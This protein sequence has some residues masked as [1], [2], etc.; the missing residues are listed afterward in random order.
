MI[1]SLLV[2]GSKIN[3]AKSHLKKLSL[4]GLN[5]LLNANFPVKKF[6]DQKKEDKVNI[7]IPYTMKL[8]LQ[9]L[10]SMSIAAR[11]VTDEAISNKPVFKY[12]FDNI[13]NFSTENDFIDDEDDFNEDDL[14]EESSN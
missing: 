3:K 9:E 13:K 12:L 1:I 5:W 2:K 6:P 14:N 8:L 4:K 7:N 11:V 10:Q